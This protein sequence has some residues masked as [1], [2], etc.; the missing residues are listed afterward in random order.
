MSEVVHWTNSIQVSEFHSPYSPNRVTASDGE[1]YNK[2]IKN[3]LPI[4]MPSRLMRQ[5]SNE[6]RGFGQPVFH[7][8]PDN[9]IMIKASNRPPMYYMALGRIFGAVTVYSLRGDGVTLP[10]SLSSA[11]LKFMTARP[12]TAV[13]SLLLWFAFLVGRISC[14]FLFLEIIRMMYER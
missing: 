8:L 7:A 6:V 14:C 1:N 9:S 2:D 5:V 3:P 13:R 4:S 12:I 10:V 11:L